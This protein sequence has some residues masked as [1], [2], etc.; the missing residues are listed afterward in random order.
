MGPNPCRRND[1]MLPSSPIRARSKAKKAIGLCTL[2]WMLIVDIDTSQAIWSSHFRWEELN[3]PI[4]CE[5]DTEIF[6]RKHIKEWRCNRIDPPE[7]DRDEKA[8]WQNQPSVWSCVALTRA[9]K[10]ELVCA[11]SPNINLDGS[12][13]YNADLGYRCLILVCD[14]SKGRWKYNYDCLP[15]Y[16]DSYW[17]GHHTLL[18]TREVEAMENQDADQTIEDLQKKPEFSSCV[19]HGYTPRGIYEYDVAAFWCTINR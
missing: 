5:G 2:L 7:C 8:V 16:T 15:G 12:V 11:G 3:T 18:T 17:Y 1:F 6:W 14:R 9:E 10:A 19:M 4:S 13:K